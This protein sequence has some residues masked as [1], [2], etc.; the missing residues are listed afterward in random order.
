MTSDREEFYKFVKGRLKEFFEGK[1]AMRAGKNCFGPFKISFLKS[2]F[3]I[4]K[5]I[6]QKS[7]FVC[8]SSS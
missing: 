5:I 6:F 4:P 2:M 8:F 7:I 3:I 1:I